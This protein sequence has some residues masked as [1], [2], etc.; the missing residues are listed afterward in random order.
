MRLSTLK[1]NALVCDE[2]YN[3]RGTVLTN[4]FNAALLEAFRFHGIAKDTFDNRNPNQGFL[5]Q[6]VYKSAGR[7]GC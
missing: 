2:L 3:S 5:T 4:I 1:V 6:I 7:F